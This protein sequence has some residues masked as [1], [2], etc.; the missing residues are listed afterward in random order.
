MN[1]GQPMLLASP[2][3]TADDYVFPERTPLSPDA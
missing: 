3:L 1:E 2:D